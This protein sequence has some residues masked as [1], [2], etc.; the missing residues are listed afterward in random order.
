MNFNYVVRYKAKTEKER[1]ACHMEG[2]LP[3]GLVCRNGNPG[4]FVM[5]YEE[6]IALREEMAQQFHDT[7][8]TVE[9]SLI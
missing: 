7:E 2:I 4:D 9:R 6:A 3:E 8:Y 5:P 1:A